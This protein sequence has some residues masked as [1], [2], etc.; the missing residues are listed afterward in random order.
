MC[1]KNQLFEQVKQL[2]DCERMNQRVEDSNNQL[3]KI[4][5]LLHEY[6][7]DFMGFLVLVLLIPRIYSL[8]NTFWVGH[9]DYSALAIAEQYEFMGILIE[10][11]NETIPFGILALISQ[12]FR[13]RE[14][15]VKQLLAGVVLQFVL[16]SLMG[17]FILLNINQFVDFIGTAPELVAQTVSYLSLRALALPFASMA[18]ILVVGLKSMD[19]AKLALGVV[20]VNVA[21]NMLSDVFLVSQLPFS[22]QLG[23]NGVAIG[24][25]FSSFIFFLISAFMCVRT[26]QLKK[27]DF[28]TDHLKSQFQ[29]IFRIGGWTGFD[30][31]V[32][33]F[34]Y[35]FVLQILNFMGPDQYAG[36]ALFQRLMWTALIPVIALADGTSIRVGNYLK[37]ESANRDIPR[38][39]FTSCAIAFLIIGG[40]G[41]LGLFAI[42][43][44]GFIFTDNPAVVRYSSE[45]F[46]WQILPYM[47]FAVAMNLR[48]VFLGTGKTY[49]ILLISLVLNFAIILPF[50]VMIDAAILPQAFVTIMLMFVI[51]DVVDI[52]IT[53]ILVRRLLGRLF[54]LKKAEMMI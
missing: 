5:T 17:G 12:N 13:N 49:Y 41:L 53:F 50:F 40:F 8:T 3:S 9:I 10:I 23:L 1:L 15:I 33:N 39:L 11:V 26:L 46:V 43:G 47:L 29:P 48:G 22:L 19:R 42:D 38:L 34:F 16:S 31:L 27:Q 21:V 25:F 44:L 36:F 28:V 7:W 6:P 37:T 18:Y 52:G 32:R 54:P 35:F 14:G 30:S 4:K 2:E 51:I 24:Y 45:M 20:V